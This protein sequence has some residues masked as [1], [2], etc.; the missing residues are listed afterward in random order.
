MG[1][2]ISCPVGKIP[3]DFQPPESLIQATRAEASAEDSRLHD[4]QKDQSESCSSHHLE[5]TRRGQQSSNPTSGP[6]TGKRQFT[7]LDPDLQ[8]KE[9]PE[10]IK[11]SGIF[12]SSFIS[13]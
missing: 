1:C 8:M 11:E 4:Q 3:A 7:F 6:V 2:A 13:W 12:N 10:S 9:Q 5:Q